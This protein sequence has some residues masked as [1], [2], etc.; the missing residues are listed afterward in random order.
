MSITS[1]AVVLVS[2]GID[3]VTLLH[4]VK[5]RLTIERICALTF[6]Y[7]Q[8]HSREIAMARRQAQSVGVFEHREIDISF[9]REITAGSAL[10]DL[11]VG[12]PALA[13]LTDDQRRQPPTYVPNRNAVL[14]SLAASHA[15]SRGIKDIYYGA[16]ALDEYGYW[17]CTPEFV[18]RLN[19]VFDLNRREAVKVHAPFT[20]MK[21]ADVLRL[22]LELGVDYS[23][24]WSC[25]RGESAPCGTCPSCFERKKAFREI[26]RSD[27]LE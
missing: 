23:L 1:K 4:Y 24:T 15:E 17:D 27:P 18:A 13:D 3:S 7:G 20:G 22:G 10:T 11:N 19:A 6:F 12:I 8:K 16:Q 2:G 14:L 21:K 25:Y 26:G 5:R 9:F